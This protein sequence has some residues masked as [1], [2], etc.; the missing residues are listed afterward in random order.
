MV[1]DPAN[2]VLRELPIDFKSELAELKDIYSLYSKEER[3][4]KPKP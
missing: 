3:K 1:Y 4:R 2:G